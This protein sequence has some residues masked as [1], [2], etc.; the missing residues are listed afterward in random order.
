MSFQRDEYELVRKR[1]IFA[2]GLFPKLAIVV[3]EKYGREENQEKVS[4]VVVTL[5]GKYVTTQRVFYKL[6][7]KSATREDFVRQI[8]ELPQNIKPTCWAKL[9]MT[10]LERGGTHPDI[11]S[12]FTILKDLDS[13]RTGQNISNLIRKALSLK[14]E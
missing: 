7:E 10:I 6:I 1:C 14:E 3:Y 12:R 8:D 4:F 11:P 2:K 13:K 9:G 5:D